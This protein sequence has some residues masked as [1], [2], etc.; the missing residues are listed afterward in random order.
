MYLLGE[1]W[2]YWKNLTVPLTPKLAL[3]HGCI[4]AQISTPKYIGQYASL[5]SC[6]EHTKSH[7]KVMVI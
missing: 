5:T 3:R 7:V 4:S 1:N 2:I 6:N